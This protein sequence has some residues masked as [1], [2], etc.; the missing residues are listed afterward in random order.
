MARTRSLHLV[1]RDETI[2]WLISK[3]FTVKQIRRAVGC[4]TRVIARVRRAGGPNI[5][6]VRRQLVAPLLEAGLTPYKAA[7][8]AGVCPSIA[9][10]LR[11]IAAR[12]E[13]ERRAPIN[14]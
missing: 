1:K 7:A 13:F 12:A 3:G 10:R 8:V 4:H 9:Y 2:A 14:G 11:G 5:R 6:E